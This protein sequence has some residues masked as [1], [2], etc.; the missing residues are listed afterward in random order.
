MPASLDR[1][2][3]DIKTAMLSGDTVTRETLR[4]IVS[5][6]RAV[7]MNNAEQLTDE[8]VVN[9]LLRQRKLREESAEQYRLGGRED[10]VA[11][12]QSEIEVINRYLPAQLSDAEVE[13]A[14]DKAVADSG[15]SSMQDMG[16]VMGV[17]QGALK[18]KAD[19]KK[20]SALVKARLG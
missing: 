20:V 5:D 18:G 12:V 19:M 14:V 3:Q 15:A 1:I 10:L 7:Q 4:L 17:L 11:Q 9:V 6:A 16:K 8:D 2:Q 13:A